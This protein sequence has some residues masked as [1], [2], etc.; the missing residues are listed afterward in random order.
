VARRF[1]TPLA[2]ALAACALLVAACGGDEETSAT[3]SPA[4]AE[5][6]IE[7]TWAAFVAAAAKGDGQAACAELSEELA[8]PNELNF[9]IGSAVEGGPSCEDTIAAEDAF[10]TGLNEEFAELEVEGTTASGIAG[11]A[12]PT[13]A[14]TDGEWKITSIFGVQPEE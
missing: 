5:A 4:D 2:A 11:A 9:Q 1:R 8:R 12:K 10:L 13:F 6:A 3:P 7:E 14:E